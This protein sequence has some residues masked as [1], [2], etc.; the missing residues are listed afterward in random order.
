MTPCMKTFACGSVVPGC[1]QSF[2]AETEDEI[3]AA[4]AAHARDD[5]GL[6]E[7]P[8]ELVAQVRANIAG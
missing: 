5:H 4:V 8:A 2:R 7:V 3:L 1:T 6:A